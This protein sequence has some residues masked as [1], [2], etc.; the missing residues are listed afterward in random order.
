[1]YSTLCN[2]HT[3]FVLMVFH[4]SKQLSVTYVVNIVVKYTVT[5]TNSNLCNPKFNLIVA[6]RH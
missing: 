1:M 6:V 2:I 3:F 4:F 5:R